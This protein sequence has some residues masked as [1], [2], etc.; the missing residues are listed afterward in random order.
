MYSTDSSNI[1][2][3]I[4][5]K[6]PIPPPH[7]PHAFPQLF[8]MTP[9]AEKAFPS[10]WA[11]RTHADHLS[12]MSSSSHWYEVRTITYLLNYVSKIARYQ[13][14]YNPPQVIT[15]VGLYTWSLL[16]AR[17][18]LNKNAPHT[19]VSRVTREWHHLQRLEGSRCV[20]VGGSVSLGVG[21]KISRASP[22]PVSLYDQDVALSHCSSTTRAFLRVALVMVSLYS[23]G[24]D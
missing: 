6:Y 2:L 13:M 15:Q 5:T 10:V 16:R 1:V 24:S 12:Q 8:T 7:C 23:N 14:K 11:D 19:L 22:G 20:L 9:E 4:I 21:P 17:C 18:G 3:S